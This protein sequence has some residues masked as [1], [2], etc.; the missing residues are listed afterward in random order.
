[1]TTYYT[2]QSMQ[3]I[4]KRSRMVA[5]VHNEESN[6]GGGCTTVL[7]TLMVYT[8]GPIPDPFSNNLV[9]IP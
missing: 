1:M 6:Q 9:Y 2:V 5:E 4:A 7:H 3:C 8:R